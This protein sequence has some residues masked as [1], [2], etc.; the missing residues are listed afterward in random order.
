[1]RDLAALTPFL[2]P[3]V[4]GSILLFAWL[5]LMASMVNLFVGAIGKSWRIPLS[6]AEHYLMIGLAAL[7]YVL[8]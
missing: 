4:T 6:G 5:V 2:K 1:M 7:L 8:K 3:A